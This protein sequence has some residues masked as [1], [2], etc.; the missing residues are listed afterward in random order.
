MR[1]GSACVT[2][3]CLVLTFPWAVVA[4]LKKDAPP[5]GMPCRSATVVPK[6]VSAVSR[7]SSPRMRTSRT[8]ALRL[9]VTLNSTFVR[10]ATNESSTLGPAVSLKK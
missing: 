2:S 9:P 10:V 1:S 5:E 7:I 4:L 6:Y 8:G 3:N